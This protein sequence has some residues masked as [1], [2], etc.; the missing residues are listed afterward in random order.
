[1]IW[2]LAIVAGVVAGLVTGG[3]LENFARLRF[4]WP[5]VVVVAVV[6]RLV[7]LESP[8]NR[9]D[10]AQWVYAASLAVVVL[11][12]LWNLDRMP[13]VWLASTGAVMNLVVIVANDARMPVAP[14]L[15]GSLVSR[16][17]IGQYVL[18]GSGTRL[19]SLADWISLRP[20]PEAYSPGDLVI[21]AGLALVAFLAI[22][23]TAGKA[24]DSARAGRIVNGPP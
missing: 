14:A 3:R 17:Q 18:M 6:V 19:N 10:G 13:G 24:P 9:V 4:R 2:L 12:T 22:R 5:Y 20:I 11:W 16:G 1:V 8:L 23:R 7:V 15:A 21:A